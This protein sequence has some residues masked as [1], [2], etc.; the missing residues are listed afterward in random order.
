MLARKVIDGALKEPGKSAVCILLEEWRIWLFFAIASFFA[1]SILMTGWPAGLIPNIRY[2]YT[3]TGD[4]LFCLSFIQ[5]LIDGVWIFFNDRMGFPFGSSG[6]DFPVPDAG[7]LLILQVFGKFWGASPAA[8]NVY[9]L[10]SF[11]LTVICSYVFLRIIGLSRSFSVAAALLFAFLPFHFQRIPH[12]FYTWYFAVPVFFYFGLKIFSLKPR[13]LRGGEFRCWSLWQVAVLFALGFFGVYYA[14]FGCLILFISAIAGAIRNKLHGSLMIGFAALAIVFCGVLVSVAPNLQHKIV[15]G[16]NPEITKREP[17]DSEIYGLKLVQM[18]LPHLGHRNEYLNKLAQN[19]RRGFPLVNENATS[20][21]GVVGAV[22]FVSL[23]VVALILMCGRQVDPRLAFFSMS[24][25]FLFLFSTIGGFSSLFAM[26][27]SPLLRGWNRVSVFIGFG[28]IAS[29]FLILQ[30][31]LKRFFPEAA[32]K[33]MLLPVA[34]GLCALGFWDQTRPPHVS[35]NDAIRLAFSSDQAFI[36]GIEGIVPKGSAIYQLPYMRFPE[37]APVNRLNNYD[38]VIAFLH[39]KSLRWSHGGMKG[40]EGDLFFRALAQQ[41]I[42]KQVEVISRLGFAGIYI[43]L[44]G[45]Q[46]Y[47]RELEGQLQQILGG[48]PQLQSAE[49]N[50]VFF[51]IPHTET[52]LKSGLTPQQIMAQGGFWADQYGSFYQATLA[53]GIDFRR[54]ERPGFIKEVKGLSGTEFF[55][56]WSDAKINK[57]VEVEFV[58]PLPTSFVLILR[59][60]PFGRNVGVPVQIKIG[61]YSGAVVFLGGMEE[62]RIKVVMKTPCAKIQI[63]PPF[64]ESP[65]SIGLSSDDRELGL[66]FER[67]WIEEN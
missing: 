33:K 1:A 55:G 23:L 51:K 29:V 15:A 41:P 60:Q 54:G 34:I 17:A 37:A 6:L 42:Q 59:A 26:A 40:R 32:V 52:P 12:L 57:F 5:R 19:Y 14:F 35:D 10:M 30:I 56:R 3:Y 53:E 43:D 18:L 64:P 28:S 58:K 49:G 11:P 36:K 46:D 20:A 24:A 66:G 63:F 45:F 44:R 47:G 13:C 9:F 38:L 21:L 8:M 31:S 62:K 65:A 67:L 61:D 4:G 27:V 48:G 7:S 25:M 16:D 50:L 39:S 22:G 2:P